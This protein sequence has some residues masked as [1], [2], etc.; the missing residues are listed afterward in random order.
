MN[1]SLTARMKDLLQRRQLKGSLAKIALTLS[2]M[3]IFL[4]TYILIAPVLTQE[5]DPICGMEEHVHTDE[6]YSLVPA[7]SL[8]ATEPADPSEP[9]EPSEPEQPAAPAESGQGGHVHTDECYAEVPVEST[10]PE[11]GGHQHTDECYEIIP[12]EPGHTHSDSCYTESSELTCGMSEHSHSDSCLDEEGNQICGEDEHSHSDSCYES[13]RELTCGQE[14]TEGTPE[15]KRLVC[16]LDETE[17]QAPEQKTERV[18]ICGME[19]GQ[20]EG[21]GEDQNETSNENQ[22]ENQNEDASESQQAPED[23]T[24]EEQP[25]MVRVLTCGKEEHRHTDQCYYKP[26]ETETVYYCGFDTEHTHDDSCY[27]ESGELKCTIPEHTHDETCLIPQVTVSQVSGIFPAELPDGYIQ[28]PSMDESAAFAIDEAGQPV[29]QGIKA[30]VY[31]PE[32]AFEEGQEIVFVS[33]PLDEQTEEYNEFAGALAEEQGDEE[34]YN[35]LTAMDLGFY[36]ENGDEVEPNT[37]NGPVY[38]RLT[39][40]MELAE[41]PDFDLWHYHDAESQAES[42]E[43]AENALEQMDV[44]YN[45]EDGILTVD[46]AADSFSPFAL[47]MKAKAAETVGSVRWSTAKA[48]SETVASTDS[49][50]VSQ[51]DISA[52]DYRYLTVTVT[53]N[54]A[55]STKITLPYTASGDAGRNTG[56]IQLNADGIHS[57]ESWKVTPNA[58]KGNVVIEYT[59][60]GNNSLDVEYKFDCWNVVSDEEFTIPYKIQQGTGAQVSEKELK[61]KIRTGH[62]VSFEEYIKPGAIESD[63]SFNGF[64]G[65]DKK[66]AYI[67]QWNSVYQTYFGVNE[68]DAAYIY[69]IAPFVVKPG[70]QQPYSISG[71]FEPKDNGEAVGAI[72]MMASKKDPD[73]LWFDV[74][75]TPSENGSNFTVTTDQLKIDDRIAVVSNLSET[76]DSKVYTLYFLVR[77][78]K[79]GMKEKISLNADLTLNHTGIDSGDPKSAKQSV[80]LYDGAKKPDQRIYWTSYVKDTVKSATGLTALQNGSAAT[81]ELAADFFCLNEA[82]TDRKDTDRY[83][84]EAIID[85]SYQTNGEFKQLSGDYRFSS[86][87]LSLIDA[88]GSWSQDWDGGQNGYLGTPNVGWT[89]DK[90][91]PEKAPNE[92]IAVYGSKSLTGNEWEPIGTTI[93]AKDVWAINSDRDVKNGGDREIDGNYVRLKVVYNS[94]LT[95][96]LRVNYKMEIKSLPNTKVEEASLTCWSNYLAYLSN[97]ERDPQM[98]FTRYPVLDDGPNGNKDWDHGTGSTM[99]LVRQHD[100]Q[101]PYPGY[102][103]T[104]SYSLRNFAKAT[105][106][107]GGDAAGM[108]VTQALYDSSGNL[109]GDPISIDPNTKDSYS[110]KKEVYNVSEVVYSF[111]GAVTDGSSSLEALQD[112]INKA[113]ADS[114]YKSLKMRYYV[115]LP[116]GLKV[117]DNPDNGEKTDDGAPKYHFWTPGTTEYLSAVSAFYNNNSNKVV[118]SGQTDVPVSAANISGWKRLSSNSLLSEMFWDAAGAVTH[119]TALSDGQLVVFDRTLDGYA[120]DQFNLWGDS[121]FFWGRG[122]SFSAVPENGTGTLPAGDYEA[123]FYCQFLD[124]NDNPISLDDFDVNN[125]GKPV[126]PSEL[127]LNVEANKN[128]LMYVPVTFHNNSGRGESIGGIKVS[129]DQ[130]CGEYE[131]EYVVG[132]NETYKYELRY[133]VTGG[134]PTKDVVL[135]CNVENYAGS[136]WN[137]VVT[138]VALDSA[139]AGTEVYVRTEVFDESQYLAYDD[140]NSSKN[141]QKS[142]L[143]SPEYGWKKVNLQDTTF[144]W[145][146]VKAIAFSFEDQTFTADTGPVSVCINMKATGG[147]VKTKPNQTYYKTQNT[148]IVTNVR[149]MD[150]GKTS[151]ISWAEGPTT[152]YIALGYTLPSTGGDGTEIVYTAGMA[153]ILAAACLM[154]QNLRRS[155]S[156]GK[157]GPA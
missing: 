22:N 55:T 72:Y 89:Q 95:T 1:R 117:N 23:Q 110:M 131:G 65:V 133:Q 41:E 144:D 148:Y 32:N 44:D 40:P 93:P 137:G 156:T 113:G 109:I 75:L 68:F 48:G 50:G 80:C 135:W 130:P 33:Q 8:N 49:D 116:E 63:Y 91:N 78:P 128:T 153:L 60:S 138:G 151:P 123:K 42:Q 114:P 125:S 103:G 73:A 105:L 52:T 92:N 58:E 121:T 87:N 81:V 38:V 4:I 141:A 10:E 39:I 51:W 127:E 149:Q 21:Q 155:R 106:A 112:R 61:G 16:G 124:E 86:F 136:E 101:N 15:E 147:N 13:H 143:T 79:A 56:A 27:F 59:G 24:G 142:W 100:E 76:V 154:Y 102:K 122:L 53:I 74:P 99:E 134:K 45:Y 77:Y 146:S 18:L 36:N 12:G 54:V 64:G 150:G 94:H 107:K 19:E 37:E 17:A 7:D 31:A 140:T 69:D 46:F 14:E 29:A 35:S 71:T 82:R 6:C 25:E 9:A 28:I 83:R 120:W 119:N 145:A 90:F 47:R 67:Q 62:S 20:E 139:P 30:Q 5:W 108:L 84:L 132:L 96:A 129:V 111:S 88:K 152:L 26:D 126:D 115:L 3:A 43:D 118:Q 57:D 2:C 85:L 11:Q 97:D 66:T 98:N 157:G 34:A 70:Q 104:T